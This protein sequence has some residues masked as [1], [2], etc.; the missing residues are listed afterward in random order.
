M[1]PITKYASIGG[2]IA[3]GFV[4]LTVL[5]GS[6][7]TVDQT[8]RGVL[9]RNGAYVKTVEPGLGFKWPWIES[10]EKISIKTQTYSWEKVNSYSNDQQPADLKLSVTFAVDPTKVG[11]LYAQFGSTKAAVGSVIS[12]VVN[13]QTKIVFGRYTAERAIRERG[14]LNQQ[15][16]D[17]IDKALE[18]YSMFQIN[19]VQI[20]N[21]DFS[22]DYIKSVE[23]RMK[24]EVEVQRLAQQALQ[25][26]Q[27]ALITVTQAQARADAVRAE[28]QAQADAI[29]LR[30]DAEAAAVKAKG[31]A[32]RENP[33]LVSLVQAERW[34][35]IL[36][37]T[38]IPGG[39][40][41]MINLVK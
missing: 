35:G 17:A 37:T 6:W 8:E 4:G 29:R 34:N 21:I 5:L 33:A 18:P 39:A 27:Q 40:T 1:N 31:D 2:F 38:M 14:A 28:A 7:Y 26:K 3:A 41:P 16:A 24:A 19:A 10:V 23:E 22:A 13:Q 25:A 12:P 30:G 9:L 36:P 32:L 20:E 15:T 11:Q